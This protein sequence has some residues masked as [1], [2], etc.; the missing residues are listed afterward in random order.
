M[1]T[2]PSNTVAATAEEP[3]AG[4]LDL[5]GFAVLSF[6][7]YG[8]LIDW[9]SGIL[10]ALRPI[11][12]AHGVQVSDDAALAAYAQ[13]ETAAE[14]GPYQAYAAILH[15]A[16]I[17]IGERLGFSPLAEEADRFASS[18][19]DWPPFPDSVDALAR[20]RTRYRLAALTNC[21]DNLFAHSSRRLGDPFSWVITA[22]QL[23]SYKPALRNFV[24]AIERTGVPA[25]RLLHVAQSLFHDHAPAKELGLRTVWVNRRRGRAGAGATPLAVGVRPELEVPDLATLAGLAGV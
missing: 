2:R 9:E 23:H 12:A 18:I 24:A 14:A 21:D 22:Q 5:R 10:S 16:L 6:D 20:L 7:C 11:L 8:T 15:L 4:A 3:G 25:D 1:T 19:A 13:A 17:G